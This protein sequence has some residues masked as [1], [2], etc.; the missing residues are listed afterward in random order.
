MSSIILKP[1]QAVAY[2]DIS[3]F[4]GSH[5]PFSLNSGNARGKFFVLSG[6]AGTGKTKLL[7]YI[8]ETIARFGAGFSSPTNKATKVLQTTLGTRANCKTIYSLL[9]IK[10]VADEDRLIL[11][12][13]RIPVDLSGYAVIFIDE[14]SMISAALLDYIIERSRYYQ[15]KWIFTGDRGQ[16]PPVGEKR[17]KVWTLDCESAHLDEVVRHDN[18]ILNLATRIRK[19][20]QRY[21]RNPDPIIRVRSDHSTNEGVWKYSRSGFM[22]QIERAAKKGLFTEVDHTKAIAWRN[23]TVDELNEFIRYQ[24]FGPQAD[25]MPYIV[26]DRLMIGEPVMSKG[27]TLAHIDDEGTILE[28]T[29]SHHTDYKEYDA[30][31]ITL[32]I[33]DGVTIDLSILHPN[34]E[35]KFL[36]TLNRM[37]ADAKKDP[38]KWKDFWMLKNSFHK[39]RHSY[40][41]TTHRSQGSTYKNVFIDTADVLANSN[42]FE[43]L[44]CL[45]V[46]FTRPTTML[47]AV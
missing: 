27:Q 25:K 42:S 11:E 38:T 43:A 23:R 24:I 14:A 34:S 16:I 22:K 20:I 12:F 33:D 3:K 30:Y 31:K 28:Q 40:A 17:S 21:K 10:M 45:Y 2:D 5:A 36:V 26:G 29:V 46:G 9:G 44:R 47:I 13:P 1:Q 8:F 4:L 39:V 18:E 15:T 7:G 37:A 35:R 32:G 6:W 19:A 41:I